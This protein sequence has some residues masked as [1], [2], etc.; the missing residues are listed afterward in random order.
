[1]AERKNTVF[2]RPGGYAQPR[3]AKQVQYDVA[4][5][6]KAAGDAKKIL[7]F[8]DTED[9]HQSLN[10]AQLHKSMKPRY[11]CSNP[12]T[13][14]YVGDCRDVLASL[15]EKG[16]VDLIFADPPFNW[17]VPYDSWKD[18]MPRAEYERFTFDW[19]DGCIDALAPHGSLWVNIPDDTAAEAVLHL[20][21]RGL[22]MI[23]WCVWHFRFGQNRNSSFILSK[24]H[25]L[26]F[27]KDPDNRIWNPNDVLE[28]SD[29]ASIYF[30]PRTMAKG[31][32]KGL[33]VPM[34]VWYGKYWGRIQGNNKERRHNHHNQIP[35]I[36]LER[37]IK[38]CSN[39]GDLVLDP[40]CGSGT[41]STVAR[42]L[43]RRSITIEY[44][45][46]N[47]QSAWE[48]ITKV[49]MVPRQEAGKP[50]STAIFK[51]RRRQ[52]TKPRT[53]GA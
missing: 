7:M 1:M 4:L 52:A 16:S 17:D 13:R 39:P 5:D 36:Y 53:V 18:G 11:S 37:I 25:V 48:R 8:G 45:A 24:V 47:A 2:A 40:F 28:V 30:D 21:R 12:D 31:A 49:G 33:R 27:A 9:P 43:G 29:R 19:L 6:L 15:P 38:A 10:G 50:Q 14:L 22:T 23:N 41:T 44:S 32:N 46:V 35:E 34:D 3:G 51:A 42:A 20:K 26:Y